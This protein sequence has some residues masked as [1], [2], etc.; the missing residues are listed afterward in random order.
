MKSSPVSS[1]YAKAL[2]LETGL[3]QSLFQQVESFIRLLSS[4]DDLHRFLM[5]SSV[6][7]QVKVNTVRKLFS[8]KFSSLFVDFLAIIIRHRREAL[9]RDILDRYKRIHLDSSGILEGVLISSV[10]LD[11]DFLIR[12]GKVFESFSFVGGKKIRL[13]NKVD[14]SILGGFLLKCDTLGVSY[15]GTLRMRLQRMGRIVG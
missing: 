1:R 9:I 12:I 4:S 11:D 2:F 6:R 13:E 15:D 3:D 5:D 10:A 14:P 8:E 7:C